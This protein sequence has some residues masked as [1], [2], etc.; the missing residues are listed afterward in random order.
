[1]GSWHTLGERERECVCV[2]VFDHGLAT[3]VGARESQVALRFTY[4]TE[5]PG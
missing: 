2:C 3:Q 5:A 1:M 4:S